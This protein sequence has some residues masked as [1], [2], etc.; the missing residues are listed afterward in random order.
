MYK[1]EKITEPPDGI[2]VQRVVESHDFKREKWLIADG[3]E[4]IKDSFIPTGIACCFLRLSQSTEGSVR[5]G[6][7]GNY[8]LSSCRSGGWLVTSFSQE[9]PAYWIPQNIC[10]RSLDAN[11]HILTQAVAGTAG[12]NISDSN[13]TVECSI[14]KNLSLDLVFWKIPAEASKI[15]SELEQPAALETQPFFMFGS[16]AFQPSMAYQKPAGLYAHLVHGHVYENHAIWPRYWR[17]CSEFDAYALYLTLSGL[18]SA[19]HKRIYSL[20]KEQILFS[21]IARQSGDGGWYHGEWTDRMESHSRFHCAAM[22]L[23]TH[24][25]EEQ[26]D[27]IVR[28][29]LEKAASFI[30]KQTDKIKAG[31]W[32]LHDSL[33]ASLETQRLSPFR[34]ARST[35]LGKSPSNMLVLNTHL[36]AII[37]LIRYEQVTGDKQYAALVSSAC[38]AAKAVLDLRTAEWIYRPLF[39]AIGL[40]LLPVSAQK[41]LS[42]PMKAVKRLA[43]KFFIPWLYRIRNMFPRLVM[44]GGY[45]DRALS[46]TGLADAYHT[47]NVMDLIRYNKLFQEDDL[48]EIIDKAL[49]FTQKH[50]IRT[51]WAETKGKE[52]ALGFW[53]EALYHMC[54]LSDDP[55]YRNWLAE[56][57]IDLEGKG[58]GLPPSLLGAN[59]E[60]VPV[61]ERLPCPLP[62]DGSLKIANLSRKGHIEIVV[63][64]PTGAALNFKGQ[65][66]PPHSWIIK[67]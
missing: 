28:K 29:A 47:L 20:M 11:K 30:S 37:A 19:T 15:V 61:K 39:W 67:T 46:Q 5:F 49:E 62:E 52:Y 27:D 33:E 63:V 10:L 48:N 9:Q 60:A 40:S 4:I 17:I 31:T 18:E 44:P 45:I 56:A 54:M 65:N 43:W 7:A 16:S 2:C 3:S 6:F 38:G 8:S 21:V 1:L 41:D 59:A 26:S 22:H 25:L 35:V 58:L 50:G 57:I 13:V 34:W 23:L 12:F 32:F 53:A 64:N 24:A 51:Y 14:P 36:D 42:L 55:K 66:I